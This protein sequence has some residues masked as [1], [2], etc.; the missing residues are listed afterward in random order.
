MIEQLMREVLSSPSSVE[1]FSSFFQYA[2][3]ITGR[4]H[5]E[6]RKKIQRYWI[7]EWWKK[8]GEGKEEDDEIYFS[9]LKLLKVSKQKRRVDFCGLAQR[10]RR[11]CSSTAFWMNKMNL[12]DEKKYLNLKMNDEMTDVTE[13]KGEVKKKKKYIYILCSF[14]PFLFSKFESFVPP[15]AH[16]NTVSPGNIS[17][18]NKCI[19]VQK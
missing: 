2:K 14:P 3:K 9:S 17:W 7:D 19:F 6:K 11:H 8:R 16:S 1:L 5:N 13:K 15:R 18:T 12:E 4:R 10:R